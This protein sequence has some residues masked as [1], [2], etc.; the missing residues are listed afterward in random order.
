MS[1]NA[2]AVGKAF[3]VKPT[4]ARRV[5]AAGR[6]GK[7]L[8]TGDP[9][10][11]NRI[12]GKGVRADKIKALLSARK[13][14][15]TVARSD[16]NALGEDTLDRHFGNRMARANDVAAGTRRTSEQRLSSGVV[17]RG[18]G[19]FPGGAPGGVGKAAPGTNGMGSL[20]P[21]FRGASLKSLTPQAPSFAPKQTGA[22]APGLVAAGGSKPSTAGLS[23]VAGSTGSG[24]GSAG[25]SSGGGAGGVGKAARISLE[26]RAKGVHG[27]HLGRK[28]GQGP[29]D[30]LA[31]DVWD[32]LTKRRRS[33]GG[34]VKVVR[35]RRY[36]PEDERRHRQGALAATGMLGGSALAVSGGRD[37]ARD[38]RLQRGAPAA[39]KPGM[40]PAR[41]NGPWKDAKGKIRQ[42]SPQE[43]QGEDMAYDLRRKRHAARVEAHS[44]LANPKGV[45]VTG[46]A[47]GKL[48]GGL[49]LVGA[50]AALHRRRREPRW[51]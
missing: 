23:G 3:G 6:N 22:K 49:A 13:A 25:L 7:R 27:M 42:P 1:G 33:E 31:D 47:A 36:D 41:L 45:Q 40:P 44:R 9:E 39:L 24:T 51:D 30:D 14:G 20:V 5:P 16:V 32:A 43:R 37:I 28:Y 12:I 38:T 21:Q 26:A 10:N 11:A 18:A 35:K 50:G 17:Y 46:R 2:V 4:L 19:R 8:V 34:N 48:G 29:K 15:K